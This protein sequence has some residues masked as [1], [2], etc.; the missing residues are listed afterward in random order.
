[1]KATNSLGGKVK[2]RIAFLKDVF[3]SL[4]KSQSSG[5]ESLLQR[6]KLYG[7]SEFKL[8]LFF[9]WDCSSDVK[10]CQ[11]QNESRRLSIQYDIFP[12]RTKRNKRTEQKQTHMGV[13]PSRTGKSFEWSFIWHNKL[14]FRNVQCYQ[15]LVQIYN[16]ELSFQDRTKYPPTS[17]QKYFLMKMY[18][19]AGVLWQRNLCGRTLKQDKR[20]IPR[21]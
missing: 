4:P 18:L 1:M 13:W 7:N 2:E 15:S 11:R 8:T 19:S 10:C 3:H 21:I 9:F 17:I 5:D 14:N 20:W 16:I 12:G 6:N